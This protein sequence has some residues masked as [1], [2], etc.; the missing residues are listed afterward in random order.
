MLPEC[1]KEGY[2]YEIP[3]FIIETHDIEDFVEELKGFHSKFA[4]CFVR[5][6]PRDNFYHDMV[7]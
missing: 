4:D 3:K 1:R 7:G 6:E 2:L 5:S